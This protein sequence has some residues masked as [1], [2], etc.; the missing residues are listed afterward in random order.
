MPTSRARSG[1]PICWGL[2]VQPWA[3]TDPYHGVFGAPDQLGLG[4]QP[5]ARWRG[6]ALVP[7][8]AGIAKS[9]VFI[10]NLN[11]FFK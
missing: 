5:L 2:C 4:L 10:L 8:A 11:N 9:K 7:L 6:C 3:V 1:G